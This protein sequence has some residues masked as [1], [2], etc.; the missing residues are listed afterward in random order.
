[1]CVL[2]LDA[3]EP[4]SR[5]D[6]SAASFA[7]EEGRC[8]LIALNK[9][10]A[11]EDPRGVIRELNERLQESLSQV[12][13]I[14]VV[15]LSALTG[16]GCDKLLPAV[17]RQYALWNKRIKTGPLNRW[18]EGILQANPPPVVDRRR[19]R[20]RYM[21]QASARPPTFVLFSSK[22]ADLPDSYVRYAVNDLR[23]RFGLPGIPIRMSVRKSAA[24]RTRPKPLR[25][26]RH[27]KRGGGKNA[28]GS[29][30]KSR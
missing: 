19:I 28:A 26:S 16:H 10:D 7:I 6:L 11:V 8:V 21:T 24:E 15:P 2:V 18:L 12:Q 3:T 13:G 22:P 1:V 25:L 20:I 27:K 23:Q 30:P 5:A 17:L 9:I 14:P 4:M 29:A